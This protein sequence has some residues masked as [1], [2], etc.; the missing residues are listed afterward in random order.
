MKR[1]LAFMHFKNYVDFC[2]SQYNGKQHI[3]QQNSIYHFW[4]EISTDSKSKL[5]TIRLSCIHTYAHRKQAKILSK[6]YY[7]GMNFIQIL[8]QISWMK[9]KSKIFG[10]NSLSFFILYSSCICFSLLL[11]QISFYFIKLFI[12]YASLIIIS[13]CA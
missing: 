5:I 8:M 13:W 9:S 4:L 6:F 1:N 2:N 3:L 10:H 7:S 12:F 11:T